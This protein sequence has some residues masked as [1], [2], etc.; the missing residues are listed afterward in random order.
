MPDR[1]PT[2][3]AATAI[4]DEYERSDHP[5]RAAL[6]EV[7]VSRAE[8]VE[9]HSRGRERERRVIEEVVD[10]VAPAGDESVEV[11]E[12][13][14][15]PRVQATFAR[16]SGRERRD[17]EGLRDEEEESGGD[18][19]RQGGRAGGRGERHPARRKDRRHVHQDQVAGAEL[20]T[21]FGHGIAAS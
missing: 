20:A 10:P 16:E 2:T 19:E 13:P 14:L 4:D 3:L 9:A 12:R 5:V 11:A 17:A 6:L 21:Q 15:A 18:P 8:D 1:Q 7:R